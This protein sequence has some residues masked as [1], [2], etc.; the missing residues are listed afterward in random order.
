MRVAAASTAIRLFQ[1]TPSHGGRPLTLL[2]VYG[3]WRPFQST[4][5]HG[6]RPAARQ[7]RSP[8]TMF[9]S[10]PSHG[11]R[12]QS[13]PRLS[14]HILRFQSTP[15][16]GGRPAGRLAPIRG[17]GVSIHALARRA[18]ARRPRRARAPPCFNPRPRT[19]G[20]LD[21][22]EAREEH[23]LFQSTPSHGGRQGGRDRDTG[24]GWVSIHALAR[25]ATADRQLLDVVLAVS[26]HALARRATCGVGRGRAA[27]G[28]SI[29]ALARRATPHLYALVQQPT[30]PQRARTSIGSE[31]RSGHLDVGTAQVIDENDVRTSRGFHV[32]FRFAPI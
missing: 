19:E 10:T 18:T 17:A 12:P 13:F 32:R 6:G 29:H 7:R 3:Q 23:I 1:S 20:D 11:G 8:A 2:S 21:P 22:N 28:V 31:S 30:I 15:S 25:R 16:H 9:Q 5:S 4:P 27:G 26:I 14:S 24:S